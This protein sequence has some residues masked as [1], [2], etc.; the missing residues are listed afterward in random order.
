VCVALKNSSVRL[1]PFMYNEQNKQDDFNRWLP[2]LPS[3]L[4]LDANPFMTWTKEWL[5]LKEGP[6]WTDLLL[7]DPDS[8]EVECR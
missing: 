6:E 8:R 1:N 4:E 7:I 3:N 2:P 5:E